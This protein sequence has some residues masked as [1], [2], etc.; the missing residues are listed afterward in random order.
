MSSTTKQKLRLFS[1][2]LKA[3]FVN[4]WRNKFLSLASIV[5]IGIIVFIF[6]IILSIDFTVQNTLKELNQK[7]D[8]TIYLQDRVSED[9]AIVESFLANVKQIE[10]VVDVKFISKSD[11]LQQIEKLH[12]Q[13]VDFFQKYQITNP[14]PGSISIT[15]SDARYHDEIKN[16]IRTVF[17]N[18]ISSINDNTDEQ[19]QRTRK[20]VDNLKSVESFANQTVFWVFF[21]FL[22]GG[23]LIII[24]SIN[25]TIFS[26][27]KDLFIQRFVG[28]DHN[29]IRLPYILE[30]VWYS[31]SAVLASFVLLMFITKIS[32][33]GSSFTLWSFSNIQAY[34][35]FF[36]ELL[37]ATALSSIASFIVIESHLRKKLL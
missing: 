4:L 5:V 30:A 21:V 16:Y 7:V 9:G 19:S 26:R 24:N 22:I 32:D 36:I 25:I 10:G 37:A 13:T 28:A 20:I 1:L 31:T 3:S 2:S 33:T 35:I 34:Q 15:T 12:P 27:Q 18:Y 11:A 17:P 29:F 6:N 8:L 14:L 23:I